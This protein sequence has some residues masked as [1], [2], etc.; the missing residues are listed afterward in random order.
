MP[1]ERRD[2]GRARLG[3]LPRRRRR[4]STRRRC[5]LD[6]R[7]ARRSTCAFTRKDSQ[8]A[9][10]AT[11]RDRRRARPRERG[12][13][14]HPVVDAGD[15]KRSRGRPRQADVQAR[16]RREARDQVEGPAGDGGR[17][18][19]AAGHHR[20]EARR[21]DRPTHDASSCRSSRRTSRTST[22]SSIASRSAATSTRGSTLPLPEH[23]DGV[24]SSLPSTSRARGSRCA[25]GS[26]QPLVE[27][28]EDAT[29][30]VEVKHD[31]KPVA[32]AEVALIVVDEA[33]LAL[34][35]KS[36]RRSARAVLPR[37]STTDTP[38]LSTLDIV[39]DAGRRAR[40]RARA[41]SGGGSTT[42][43]HRQRQR[44]G[45]GF[46][47][48]AAACRDTAYGA[49]RAHRRSIVKARKDFRADR[50]VLAAAHDRRERQG[51]ADREDARQPHALPHRRARDREH[52]LL[53]Q[54]REHDRHAAQGQRAHRRA[55]VPD[56]G[57]YV[58]AAGRR[59]EPR[60]ARRARSTSRCAPRTSS[61]AARPAS[62][63]TIPGGQ[64][65]EVRFD[66][67]TQARGKAVVQ[68]IAT[69][70][71][72]ADASNVELPVYEP[73]TT[74]SFATYGTVDDKPA[75][76]AAR[77]ARRHLPRRRRRRGR[78]R[79]DA[80]A[81]AH[82]RV[83]VPLRV[84]VRVRRA[85]LVAHARD[86]GDVRHPRRVRDA[87]PSDAAPRSTPSATSDVQR[88]AQAIS[89]TTAAGAT[90]CGM[91]SDPFVTMQVAA[92]R[93]PRR[94]CSGES[95]VK[96]AIGSWPTQ[97]RS[98]LAALEKRAAAPRAQLQRRATTLRTASRSPPTRW[99]RSPP[100]AAD[101][102]PRVPRA[103]T[104]S[105]STLGA[106]P[107]DA[108]ARLLALVAKARAPQAD[109]REAAR[110]SCCRPFTRRPPPRRSPRTLPESE[111]LL[112]VS[113]TKTTALVLD[114]LMRETAGPPARS[115]SSRAACSTAAGTA[116]GCRR[117]R[118]SSC[119]RRCAATST[120]SRR[121]RRTTRASS[122]SATPPTPS[123]LRRPQQ[124]PRALTQL[125]WP[126]LAPG[127]T[128]DLA[129]VRSRARAHVLPRRHHV[130]AAEDRARRR[131]TPAS[132]CGAATQ[133][134]D[135]PER[136]RAARRRAL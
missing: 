111:R 51:A 72:F 119:C 112:L 38:T 77:G 79:L 104:R 1:I 55:A 23:A 17:V 90:S 133:P 130:R 118:T 48:G 35:G 66:F 96:H 15:D 95:T 99:R 28:G 113:S 135:D 85:A 12:A 105:P 120:S 89:A 59:A 80:A 63:S 5:K 70:G 46:G 101:V 54:G 98:L 136:R 84:S 127:T 82:R 11:A 108:K 86:R 18:V 68:T 114:A 19:R 91:K 65:A 100:P 60:R 47:S 49:E 109:A 20:A 25:R 7:D 62:A 87:R 76:R 116:A 75:L 73:A 43:S 58:L 74:E 126:T 16:R 125:D 56:P 10:T 41:S 52:A 4:S 36:P 67:A 132:S 106:Y 110:A 93:S 102:R 64:R 107:V 33:V 123:R 6:E 45:Y 92:R 26:L 131:S 40:R 27:P 78:A 129:L 53:R 39:D 8:T 44:H 124:R 22:S 115:P 50:G 103:C 31:D 32:G 29:F 61:P 121:T 24:R 34:S 69:S 134:V 21:A 71:D 13:V 122:G 3:A 14:R 94:R 128:H 30:E 2:R 83:L 81:V 117:R 9:Y 97:A 57:R 42:A 37:T 88:L